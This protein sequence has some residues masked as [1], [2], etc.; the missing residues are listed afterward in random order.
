MQQKKSVLP[1][2]FG[3][4]ENICHTA[5]SKLVG[6]CL[7]LILCRSICYRALLLFSVKYSTVKKKKGC[8]GLFAFE[9]CLL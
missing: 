5:I 2:A 1:Q 4:S 9:I 6:F 3:F 8:M 7:S